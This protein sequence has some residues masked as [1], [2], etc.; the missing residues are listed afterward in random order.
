MLLLDD[1]YTLKRIVL[2][3][4]LRPQ[5]SRITKPAKITAGT[6]SSMRLATLIFS[7]VKHITK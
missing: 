5:Q 2:T 4:N 3:T 1:P 7:W 6:T